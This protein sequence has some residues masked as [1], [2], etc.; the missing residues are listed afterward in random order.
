MRIVIK[1]ESKLIV[2]RLLTQQQL[3]PVWEKT[4]RLASSAFNAQLCIQIL[5]EEK[6]ISEEWRIHVRRL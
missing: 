5:K 6:T 1:F 4:L 3:T 2:T